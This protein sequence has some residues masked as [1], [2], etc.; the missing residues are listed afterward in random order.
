MGGSAPG[1]S[2][3]FWLGPSPTTA[4]WRGG[5]PPLKLDVFFTSPLRAGA[6]P[7]APWAG[8]YA[9]KALAISNAVHS[10]NRVRLTVALAA[11][12][13]GPDVISYA[14]PPATVTSVPGAPAAPFANFPIT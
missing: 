13:P 6:Y 11:A 2:T 10:D 9:N 14:P 3:T 4:I 8:R 7:A 12:D 1:P 5:F